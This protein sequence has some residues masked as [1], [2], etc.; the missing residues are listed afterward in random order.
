MIPL[1]PNTY[2][3]HQRWWR[4]HW[5][6]EGSSPRGRQSAPRASEWAGRWKLRRCG[7]KLGPC[8]HRLCC[9]RN[10]RTWDSRPWIYRRH[11][12]GTWK[13]FR[14]IRIPVQTKLKMVKTTLTMWGLKSTRVTVYAMCFIKRRM[15]IEFVSLN[16]VLNRNELFS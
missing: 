10:G 7:K 1:W 6:R 4:Q 5:Q 8:P 2:N 12:R 14:M 13:L 9:S 3:F 16:H 11:D 15:S